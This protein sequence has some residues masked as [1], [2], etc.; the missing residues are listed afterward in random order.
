MKTTRKDREGF[1][2]EMQKCLME[3]KPDEMVITFREITK[4]NRVGLHS[5]SMQMPNAV[6]VP[7]FYLEDL[8]PSYE[9]GT[10]PEDIAESMINYAKENNLPCLPGNID[11]ESYKGAK[12]SLGLTILGIERN[13]EYLADM[14]YEQI[15]D[16]ALIPILFSNDAYGPGCIKI[17]KCMVEDWGVSEEEVM[18]EAKENAPRLLPLVFKQLNEALHEEEKS[19]DAELFVISNRYFAGGAAV[20][21]YPHVLE[22]IAKALGCN[23]YILPSSVNEMILMTDRG[24]DPAFLFEIVR[25]VN[26]TEVPPTEV[27]SDSIYYYSVCEDR[28]SRLLPTSF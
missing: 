3:K 5:C 26:R 19:E 20:A 11:I 2:K 12:K 18:R 24:Q 13:K 6:A 23:L 15:E 22:G 28:F 8:Y 27:L 14:V 10:A 9:N 25:E 4:Q 1:Y 7:T 21:F 17:R 16:L